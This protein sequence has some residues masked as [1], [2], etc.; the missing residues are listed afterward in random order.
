MADSQRELIL[1]A[2]AAALAVAQVDWH[3]E[4][5]TK[6]ADLNVHRHYTRMGQNADFPD[7][8]VYYAGEPEPDEDATD[9][10]KHGMLVRLRCRAKAAAGV[11]GDE[12]LD[13]VLTW[14]EIALLSEPT[15]GGLAADIRPPAADALSAREL[16][17]TYAE[18]HLQ[19]EITHFTKWGDPRQSL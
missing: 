6:P 9:G 3:S 7:I 19:F 16:T 13:P 4:I 14:A 18:T 11:S 12:A 1:K 17:E 15:L 5:T 8:T 2:V 10:A